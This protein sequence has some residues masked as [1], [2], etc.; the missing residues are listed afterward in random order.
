MPVLNLKFD[1]GAHNTVACR[2]DESDQ[3]ITVT[4]DNL[5]RLELPAGK[6]RVL[7]E[8]ISKYSSPKCFLAILHPLTFLKYS[9][10]LVQDSFLFAHDAESASIEFCV[11]LNG[12]CDVLV[13]LDVKCKQKDFKDMYYVFSVSAEG[14]ELSEVTVNRTSGRHIHRWRLVHIIP[15]IF[16]LVVLLIALIV[17]SA[18]L[19]EWIVYCAYA[20][21]AAV[22]ILNVCASSGSADA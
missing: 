1:L 18:P 19:G 14:A 3:P 11:E 6:H 7:V 4:G 10:F 22:H 2:I 12:D 5:L 16:W 20:V 21:F 9:L 13:D 15:C 17:R 8:R